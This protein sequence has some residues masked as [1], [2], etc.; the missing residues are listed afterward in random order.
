M[1]FLLSVF[2]F[3]TASHSFTQ[4]SFNTGS[5]EIDANLNEINATAK[6]DLGVFKTELKADFSVSDGD[7]DLMF[8]L[9]MEPAEAYFSLELSQIANKPLDEVMSAYKSNKDKGWG[10][11]AKQLGI[12]PGSPEFHA[13]KGKTKNKKDKSGKKG[14][15]G[16]KGNGNGNGKK[17]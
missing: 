13:L 1:K 5:S 15:S 10:F 2:L 14:N 6:L 16:N 9:G 8:S 4:I 7:I 3:I 12:K 11:I 17:K